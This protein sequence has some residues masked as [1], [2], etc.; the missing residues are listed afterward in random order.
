MTDRWTFREG[1]NTHHVFDFLFCI[2]DIIDAVNELKDADE[3]NAGLRTISSSGRISIPLRKLLLDGNG[4]LFKS[5]FTDPN[6]HP[7]KRPSPNERPI[8]FVQRLKRSTMVLEWADGEK[9]T[10]E[11]PKYEQKTTIHPLYGIRRDGDQ[12]FLIEMPF[13]YDAHPIKFKAWMNMKVLQ[14]DDMMFTAKDLLREVVNNEGAHIGDGVK[15]ALPD[16]SSLTMD[17]HKNERYKAVNAVKFGSL[18]YARMFCI[19]TGIYIT[20]RSKMLADDL[21]IDKGGN[22]AADIFKKIDECPRKLNGRGTMEN[23]TYRGLV[24]GSDRKLR[25]ESIGTYSTLMRIP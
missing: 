24:L 1:V 7:L 8:T 10:I 14:V 22:V 6:F 18:S 2:A 13:D 21:P 15:F 3:D 5:C 23:Q 19:C 4:H 20:S 11:V 12:D 9:E 25:S 16:A 17:N